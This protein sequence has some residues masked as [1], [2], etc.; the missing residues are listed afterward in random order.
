MKN[1]LPDSDISGSECQLLAFPGRDRWKVYASDDQHGWSP[2]DIVVACFNF[3]DALEQVEQD[4][5]GV[6][7]RE[8]D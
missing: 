3:E 6:F 2:A 5:S 1:V 4:E 8:R 7:W